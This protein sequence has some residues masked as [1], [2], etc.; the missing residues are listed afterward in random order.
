MLKGNKT[1]KTPLFRYSFAQE[2]NNELEEHPNRNFVQ[3][4][5]KTVS[6]VFFQ[7]LLYIPMV[8]A[9]KY[10]LDDCT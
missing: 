7:S 9:T 10:T 2:L 5:C 6:P 1:S 3:V 4:I 8:Q